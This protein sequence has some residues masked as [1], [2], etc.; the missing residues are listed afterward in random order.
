MDCPYETRREILERQW[1]N[2]TISQ[3][4]YRAGLDQVNRDY[5]RDHPTH[6]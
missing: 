6:E 1:L 3:P 5:H 4:E 2:G